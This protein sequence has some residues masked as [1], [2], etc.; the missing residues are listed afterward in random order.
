[1]SKYLD[2]YNEYKLEKDKKVLKGEI[3]SEEE[4]LDEEGNAGVKLDKDKNLRNKKTKDNKSTYTSTR[5]S[6]S[7]NTSNLSRN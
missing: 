4:V 5:T 1:M 7:T 3:E 6:T 2:L